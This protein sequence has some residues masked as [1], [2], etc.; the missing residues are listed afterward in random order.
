M[1]ENRSTSS[2]SMVYRFCACCGCGHEVVAASE[3]SS[4]QPGNQA[5]LV[6]DDRRIAA[7]SEKETLEQ[8]GKALEVIQNCG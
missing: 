4:T 8:L 6:V 7:P 3:G 1:N 5:V 2:S